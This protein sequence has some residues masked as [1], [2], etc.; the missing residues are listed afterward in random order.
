MQAAGQ[1]LFTAASNLASA[2][3]SGPAPGTPPIQTSYASAQGMIASPNIDMAIQMVSQ[4]QAALSFRAN[5]AVY[6]T[7][8]R[9]D[10][11]L[12]DTIA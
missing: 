8:S 6:R 10:Q 4:M 1:A 9:M 7:A 12:L 5:L 3:S 2:N 11:T